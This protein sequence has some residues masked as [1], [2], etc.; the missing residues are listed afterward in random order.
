MFLG[1]EIGWRG[2]LL[3]RLLKIYTP[4]ISFLIC[5]II[6]GLW[7]SAGILLGHNY[8]GTPVLG[9]FLMIGFCMLFG[10]VF[11]WLRLES[12]SVWPAVIAHGALNGAAG[13]VFLFHAEGFSHDAAYAGILGLTGWILPGCFVAY[14][15]VANRLPVSEEMAS[16]PSATRS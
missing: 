2:F 3:P 10:V 14:L 12:G 4:R 15:Y 16:N 1:E 11:G 8:P 13:S 7:H 5:G 6:W 9:T